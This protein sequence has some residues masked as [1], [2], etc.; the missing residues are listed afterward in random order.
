MK[1]FYGGTTTHLIN[2]INSSSFRDLI[3]ILTNKNNETIKEL[4]KKVK[5]KKVR[6]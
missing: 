4:K 5:G 1:T 6:L 2:L 3:T